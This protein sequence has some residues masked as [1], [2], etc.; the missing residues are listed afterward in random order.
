MPASE[1]DAEARYRR[2][3]QI[4]ED[5]IF[6]RL[7]RPVRQTDKLG[8]PGGYRAF[9]PCH[10]D[11]DT[12]SLSISPGQRKDVVWRCFACETVYGLDE[13]QRRTREALI[14][15]AGVPLSAL[16]W[17]AA[18]TEG[19]AERIDQLYARKVRGAAF[20]LWV[21]AYRESYDQLP[22]G[23]E[24]RALAERAN[25]GDDA[26]FRALREQRAGSWPSTD[27]GFILP[28]R[29]ASQIREDTAGQRAS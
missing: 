22:A 3:L 8:R 7:D 14:H 17:S 4:I 18:E 29:S 5:V 25:I 26:A 19:F 21:R 28:S 16:K 20:Q 12:R 6:A 15:I 11:I 24:L 1:A 13:A 2:G 10:E 23:D 9:A 27:S